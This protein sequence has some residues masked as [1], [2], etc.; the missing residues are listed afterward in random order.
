VLSFFDEA[1]V[2]ILED[3][4]KHINAITAK[5]GKLKYRGVTEDK[6]CHSDHHV[7]YGLGKRA[8][9]MVTK[10]SKFTTFITTSLVF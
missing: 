9:S 4:Y 5:E 6:F 10:L 7:S 2:W 3:Q 8:D 1:R